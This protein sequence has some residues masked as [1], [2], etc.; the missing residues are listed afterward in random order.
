MSGSMVLTLGLPFIIHTSLL[1][2]CTK[3][4]FYVINVCRCVS[5]QQSRINFDKIHARGSSSLFNCLSES[6]SFVGAA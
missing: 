6:S 4:K 1:I 5:G 2:E 3:M